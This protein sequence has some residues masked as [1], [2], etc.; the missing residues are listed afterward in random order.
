MPYKDPDKQR[1]A[2]RRSHA[3]HKIARNASS[4]IYC[5]KHDCLR[6]YG[7]SVDN[8]EA[9][10]ATQNGKCAICG[11]PNPGVAGRKHF[12][13]DHD[14]ATG[15]V[16]GLLCMRC[17]SALGLFQENPEIL[18]QAVLYLRNTGAAPVHRTADEV[19]GLITW[20]KVQPNPYAG[21]GA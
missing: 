18:E 5:E 17:N 15:G 16:R 7:I 14:H 2:S 11:S 19:A 12:T 20:A 3:A 6:R 4:R 8:Y 9:M 13:I 10:L 21:P 1:A